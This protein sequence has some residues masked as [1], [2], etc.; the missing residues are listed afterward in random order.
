MTKY[1]SGSYKES[2]QGSPKHI[3][4]DDIPSVEC[5]MIDAMPVSGEQTVIIEF[6]H[7]ELGKE[8][9]ALAGYYTPREEHVLLYNGRE[10]IYILGCV[11]VD[12]S[13]CGVGNWNYIQV[14]GFLVRKHIRRGETASPV[15]EIEIIQ[16]EEARSSIRQ[17][18][19]K[20]HPGAQIEIR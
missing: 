2:G 6:T 13:C 10:V 15:S 7:P 11:S 5:V 17:S 20:K 14:L 9:Q 16:D 1:C 18:L 12:T 3:H 8:V 19:R 4:R